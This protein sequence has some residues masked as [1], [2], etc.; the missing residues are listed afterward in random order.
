MFCKQTYE[1]NFKSK[2]KPG[3]KQREKFATMRFTRT[4]GN[5][6]VRKRSCFTL[7]MNKINVKYT[8]RNFNLNSTLGK[9]ISSEI[10]Y[11]QCIYVL[12]VNDIY[13]FFKHFILFYATYDF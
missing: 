5:Y 11:I 10:W 1:D 12:D 9:V 8:F 6:F 7:Y 13:L 3:S 4:L 2:E